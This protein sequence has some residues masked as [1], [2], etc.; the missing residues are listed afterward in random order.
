MDADLMIFPT[1]SDGFGLTQ[2]EAQSWQ[3]PVVASRFCGEVVKNGRNG[4]LLPEVSADVIATALKDLL[5]QPGSLRK[6]SESSL[7]DAEFSLDNVGKK[8]NELLI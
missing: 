4:V 7:V 5:M 3:L 6:M 1:F 2:L 8:W